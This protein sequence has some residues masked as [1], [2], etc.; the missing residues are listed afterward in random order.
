MRKLYFI[1]FLLG[2]VFPSYAQLS[3]RAIAMWDFSWLERRWPGAGYENW[4]KVLDEFVDRGYNAVR[5]DAYPHLVG[6]NPTGKWVLDEVWNTQLWGSPDRIEVQ[7]QPALNEFIRKCGERDIKVGLSTWIRRDTTHQEMTI[8]TPE[9]FANRWIN[10]LKTIEAEGL[11]DH[12]LYVDLCNEWPGDSWAPFFHELHPDVIWGQWHTPSSMD[13]MKRAIDCVRK[14]YPD[15]P[16][17]FSFDSQ[18]VS[19]Y[20]QTDT[21][22]ID[23]FE[24]HI[25][26]ANQNGAEFNKK[27]GYNYDK[28]SPESYKNMVRNAETLYRLTPNYWQGLLTHQICEMADMARDKRK[29]LITTECWAVIDY[30]DWPML[31]W[32]WVKELCEI[33][34]RES[35]ATGMWVAI[36]TSNFCGPQFVGMWRDVEWHRKMTS[37]IRHA[38]IDNVLLQNN[39]NT[40]KLF[41]RLK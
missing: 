30:K 6:V 14:V 32:D 19:T 7:V 20:R 22:F 27:V 1:L 11:L 38:S 33:G 41:R 8:R 13:W 35:A 39:D 15:M 31:N 16:L 3:P 4:D 40:Q 18:D 28:F 5:I 26:M 2:L 12:I 10:T 25:W 21:S 34:V 24:L 17:L 23:F 9:D 36:A 29:P 37:V